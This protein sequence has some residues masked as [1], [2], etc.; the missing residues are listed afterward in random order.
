M[1]VAAVLAVVVLVLAGAAVVA[2]PATAG[3]YSV[4]FA[5]DNFYGSWGSSTMAVGAGC[6]AAT[7]YLCVDEV[8]PGPHDGN[9]SYLQTNPGGSGEWQ[10]DFSLNWTIAPEDDVYGVTL[11]L[12]TRTATLAAWPVGAAIALLVQELGGAARLCVYE[13]AVPLPSWLPYR[14]VAYPSTYDQTCEESQ[15]HTWEVVVVFG[16]GGSCTNQIRLTAVY[17]DLLVTD[18]VGFPLSGPNLAWLLYLGII[19]GGLLLAAWVVYAWRRRRG[20]R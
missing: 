1:R 16:C 15:A 12:V 5:A 13:T 9:T 3:R 2:P 20:A 10:I 11:H 14:D 17:V 6:T 4:R 7:K 18:R 19:I 8:P